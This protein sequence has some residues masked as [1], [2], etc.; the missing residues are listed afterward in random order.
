MPRRQRP[1]RRLAQIGAARRRKARRL[2]PPERPAR[3][4]TP[5]AA[6]APGW[7][8]LDEEIAG[9]AALELGLFVRP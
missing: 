2:T 1:G 9:A 8:S 3:D 4:R 5:D 6:P 7:G